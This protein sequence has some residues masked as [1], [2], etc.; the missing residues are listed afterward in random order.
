MGI[1]VSLPKA[2]RLTVPQI[3]ARKGKEK[4]SA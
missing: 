4:S 1:G 2:P 3:R